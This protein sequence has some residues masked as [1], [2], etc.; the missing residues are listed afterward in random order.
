MTQMKVE[1][2]WIFIL[3]TRQSNHLLLVNTPDEK[4]AS[5]LSHSCK[6]IYIIHFD[7]DILQR[8]EVK[9]KAQGIHNA[10]YVNARW[11]YQLPL[12][13][14]E[15]FDGVIFSNVD[16]M[17][18]V[19]Q[20]ST[21]MDRLNYLNVFF[22]EMKR[23]LKKNGFVFASLRNRF[24]YNR[25][26]S[27]LHYRRRESDSC[28]TDK[29]MS[30]RTV[31]ASIK[32]AGF[33][34]ITRYNLITDG[35]HVSEVILERKYRPSKNSFTLKEKM[36]AQLL[37]GALS[38]Y[39]SPSVG[40]VFAKNYSQQNYLDG[41]LDELRKIVVSEEYRDD[42]HVKKYLV[43]PGK[44]ILSIGHRYKKYG[45]WIVI[46][47][48]NRVV[49]ERLRHEANIL[50]E[51]H[52]A[53][54]AVKRFVPKFLLQSE[55]LGQ[56]FF[57]QQEIPGTTIDAPVRD[58]DRITRYAL[59][60]LLQLH[61]ENVRDVVIDEKLYTELCRDPLLRVVEKIGTSAATIIKN[62]ETKLSTI[63]MNRRVKLVWAHGDYKIENL[64]IDPKFL[65]VSGIIDWDLS[66][67]NGL[68]F[69]DLIYLIVYN[70]VIRGMTNI[71]EIFI[72]IFINNGASEEERNLCNEY[73]KV[74]DLKKNELDMLINM[75]WIYHVAYR[76]DIDMSD[77]SVLE[78]HLNML[79]VIENRTSELCQITKG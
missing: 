39:F 74:I 5:A 20:Q 16:R 14:S 37:S 28:K 15:Y 47:P 23:V 62:I 55:Y 57:V 68:P 77:R 1:A 56:T 45:V 72:D 40:V 8:I 4:L 19:N 52:E 41:L 26:T 59:N 33:N 18:M 25:F 31:L 75:F 21:E 29:P 12:L 50:K 71:D 67:K 9:M 22:S 32:N 70:R 60:V 76:I 3:D 2:G 51:I 27:L 79:R 61:K 6:T 34:E 66:S 38:D 58:L 63:L 17:H 49:L 54:N 10:T 65:T 36:R 44:V 30:K 35:E 73:C 53:P 43:L 46:L 7:S 24:G 13:P 11:G 42:F 48:L 64:M 78:R 69:M